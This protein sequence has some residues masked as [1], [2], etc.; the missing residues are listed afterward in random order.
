ML[1]IEPI[2]IDDNFF[3]MGGN[4]LTAV[5]TMVELKKELRR[6]ISVAKLYQKP[7][8]RNLAELLTQDDELLQQRV[9]ALTERREKLSRRNQM[10]HKRNQA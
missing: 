3:D 8:I 2:G 10:L 7:T 1:G 4:S 9:T 6:S 5:S